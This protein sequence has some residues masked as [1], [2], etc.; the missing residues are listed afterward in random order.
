MKRVPLDSAHLASA[1]YHDPSRT[2]EIEFNKGGIY[3]YFDVPPPVYEQLTQADSSDLFFL[4][5]IRGVFR[6]A[7][8]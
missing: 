3:Q 4:E 1:G 5:E 7:R 8:T 2:L 6:Y